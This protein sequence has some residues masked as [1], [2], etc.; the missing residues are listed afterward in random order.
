MKKIICIFICFII[1]LCAL[2]GC[3]KTPAEPIVVGKNQQAMIEKAETNENKL[4]QEED[5]PRFQEEIKKD[6]LTIKVD[7]EIVMPE[8]PLSILRVE[9]MD[10]T[11][12]QVDVMWNALVKD[13]PMFQS[14]QMTKTDIEE[15]ILTLEQQMARMTNE[16]EIE[17]H[18]TAINGYREKYESAPE[19]A[20]FIPATSELQ[21]NI[22]TDYQGENVSSEY[23]WL[24][25]YEDPVNGSGKSF[26]VKN[27]YIKNG[28]PEYRNAEIS[29]H[30]SMNDYQYF[31]SEIRDDEVI[32]IQ[33][34]DPIPDVAY[35]LSITPQEAFEL[36]ET[37][38][39]ETED[40]GEFRIS[41]IKLVKN[42]IGQYAYLV[43]CQRVA[44]GISCA[45]VESESTVG[46]SE[47]Y[48]KRWVYESYELVIDNDGIRAFEWNSPMKITGT[49][50]EEAAMMSFD[51]SMVV[52]EKMMPVLY[53]AESKE[54][55]I[56]S[57]QFEISDVRLE[58]VRVLK[59]NSVDE[60]LLIPVWSF[61][62][63][64]TI[65]TNY[66]NTKTKQYHDCWLMINAVDGSIIDTAKG[67]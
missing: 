52:F 31:E 41:A 59:Q 54:E 62:G 61:Y 27:N 33:M 50:V 2:C 5:V 17:Y 42:E 15:M 21:R 44:E 16:E 66:E 64:K 34:E 35:N 7:A 45:N 11:Q 1:M 30:T 57:A 12:E 47:E 24:S 23:L 14:A 46:E 37:F 19:T 56:N 39:E 32:I 36:A 48:L 43:E 40:A 55:W 49:E 13:T 22:I 25:A 53:E 26:Y 4:E 63:T 10:F 65:H 20:E 58:Y 6:K 67:Y 60:G 8:A 51:E 29:F 18:K 3:Q 38:A 28:A 9:S